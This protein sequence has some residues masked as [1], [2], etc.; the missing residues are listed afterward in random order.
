MT[1]IDDADIVRPLGRPRFF[2]L[3]ATGTAVIFSLFQFYANGLALI[4]SFHQYGIHLGLMMILGFLI[5]PISDGKVPLLRVID[6]V[7]IAIAIGSLVFLLSRYNQMVSRFGIFRPEETFAAVLIVLAVMEFTRRVVGWPLFIIAALFILYAYFGN[8]IPG[9]F[10]HAGYS[11]TRISSYLILTSDG[12]FGTALGVAATLISIFVIFGAFLSVTGCGK[13]FMDIGNCLAGRSAGGPAKMAV[14]ASALMGSISGSAAGN[15]ATTGVFTIP[16][17]SNYGYKP[18]QAG[19]IEAA[20]STGGMILPPLMGAGAFVMAELLGIPYS[21]VALAALLPALLYFFSILMQVHFAARAQGLSGLRRED[22]VPW[23]IIVTTAYRAIPLV[24]LIYLIFVVQYSAVYAAFWSI[25]SVIVLGLIS[26]ELRR[27]GNVVEALRSAAIAMLP[28]TAACTAAGIIVGVLML[29]GLG[30][31]LSSLMI[32]LA[33]GNLPILLVLTMI[34]SIILGMGVPAT[35]AY[36]ILAALAAPALVELGVDPLG[37]HM[38]VFYFGVI[39]NITPPVAVAA[40]AAAGIAGASANKVGVEAFKMGFVAFLVPFL[41]IYAPDLLLIDAQP[42]MLVMA[43]FSAT[44][45]ITLLAAGLQGWLFDRMSVIERVILVITSL[46]FISPDLWTDLAGLAISF[47][48]AI[49]AYRRR[50]ANKE[51]QT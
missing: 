5:F 6:A 49:R 21:T 35:A 47:G 12:I 20:A 9:A 11:T 33:S 30:L 22:L 34:S 51:V 13:W 48:F 19:G 31:R 43:L 25:G 45:G 28:I 10:G 41:F 17:M 4:P 14:V 26:G 18:E 8:Y 7:I 2:A 27:V 29:T 24:V 3:I 38:F 46:L 15:V 42:L 39:S 44:I 50:P 32:G 16:L 36:I 40:F 1:K 23:R 37:A